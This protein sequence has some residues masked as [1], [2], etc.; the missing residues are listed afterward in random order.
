V[1]GIERDES[2]RVFRVRVLQRETRVVFTTEPRSVSKTDVR[3]E[4]T[5]R[6]LLGLREYRVIEVDCAN[7]TDAQPVLE[8]QQ[9]DYVI[10]TA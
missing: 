4:L 10:T 3:M 5:A 8:E 9:P 7:S 2:I 1:P 6:K